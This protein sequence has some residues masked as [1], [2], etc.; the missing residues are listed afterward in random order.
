M[1]KRSRMCIFLYTFL[2]GLAVSMTSCGTI[3]DV[4]SPQENSSNDN[5]NISSDKTDLEF[6]DLVELEFWFGSGAGA[7]CTTLKIQSDGTFKGYYSDAEAGDSGSGYNGTTYECHFNG[8][9]TSLKKV[10]ENEYSMKCESWEAEGLVDEERII[11]GTRFITAE[12]YGFENADE[13]LLYLPGKKI[14]ELPEEFLNW[15]HGLKDKG[16]LTCYGL[17]NVEGENGFIVWPE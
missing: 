10:N 12:P 15:S 4:K 5:S 17:Y 11:N 2:F 16:V 1:M 8:R 9:F 13:F 6:S 7:W 3:E 14:S